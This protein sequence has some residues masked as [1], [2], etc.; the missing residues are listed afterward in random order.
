MSRDEAVDL[1]QKHLRVEQTSDVK[2]TTDLLDIVA[3]LPLAI[4]EGSAYMDQTGMTT[5]RYIEHCRSS[6]ADLIKLLAK[7]FED[8]GRYKSIQNSVA[9]RWL[10]SF[11]HISHDNHLSALYMKFMSFL[12]EKDIPRNLLPPGDGQLEMD[13]ALGLLKTYAFISERA[14]QESYDMHRLVRLAMRN[15]LAKEGELEKS[16]TAVI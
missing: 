4:K 7:D 14:G 6:D 13:E 3:D 11:H 12:A 10:I 1:L 15:W 5:T 9:T 8:I 2:N 16:V